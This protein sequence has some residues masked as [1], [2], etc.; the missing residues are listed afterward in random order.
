MKIMMMERGIEIKIERDGCIYIYM[1]AQ[2]RER[3]ESKMWAT[4]YGVR[5]LTV[6]G[7]S[8]IK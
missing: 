7:T 6:E 3:L 1:Y 5:G 2:E 8:Y 4:E